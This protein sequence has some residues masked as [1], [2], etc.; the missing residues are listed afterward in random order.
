[1]KKPP[2]MPIS[3][4]SSSTRQV[5]AD[6]SRASAPRP[7]AGVAGEAKARSSANSVRPIEPSG[8][9]PSSMRFAE[10]F[11]QS[12][13]PTPMPKVKVASSSVTAVSLP[14]STSLV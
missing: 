2:K 6:C 5:E 4:R 8:T 12:S 14:P 3:A 1:M 13:E 10:S 7:A 9:K 11:S